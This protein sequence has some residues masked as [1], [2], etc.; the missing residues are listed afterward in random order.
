[1]QASWLQKDPSQL[2][3]SLTA[4]MPAL[5]QLPSSVHAASATVKWN[6]CVAWKSGAPV[7]NS[8]PN[9]ASVQTTT[10]GLLQLASRMGGSFVVEVA[11]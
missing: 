3:L 11:Q 2:S 10:D 6:G 9:L 5:I 4:P 1:M 7:S 8:C